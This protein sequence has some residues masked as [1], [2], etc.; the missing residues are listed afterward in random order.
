MAATSRITHGREFRRATLAGHTLVE[1]RYP[2]EAWVEPHVHAHPYLVLVLE[3]TF[4][5]RS[6][7]GRHACAPGTVMLRPAGTRH[8][9]R[10]GGA[11]ARVM[12]VGVGTREGTG[13]LFADVRHYRAGPAVSVA[14]RLYAELRRPDSASAL[15]VDGL[16]RELAGMVARYGRSRDPARRP[17]AWL[18]RARERL[19]EECLDPPLVRD[20]AEEAGV[21]P[22]HLSRTFRDH[23]GTLPGEFVRSIRLDWAAGR[24]LEGGSTV[25]AVAAR[26]GYADQSH[27]TRAFKA[28]FGIPPGR[29]RSGLQ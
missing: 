27:F 5:E 23:Y 26:A 9:D 3:G 2:P 24:L 25:A 8:S 7:R 11:G 18:A 16:M 14:A 22:D 4:E 21:H 15:V 13:D 1:S 17:P 19:R 6:R 12:I 10:F 28:R 20:L 29:Y